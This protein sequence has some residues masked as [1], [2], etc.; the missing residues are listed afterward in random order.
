ME[1]EL[2]LKYIIAQAK[3]VGKCF[4][5]SAEQG[6]DS[7]DFAKQFLTSE[8]GIDVLTDKMMIEYSAHTFMLAGFKR[9]LELKKGNFYDRDVLYL[10]GFLYKYWW[11]TRETDPRII[12]RLAPA[13]LIA[14]RYE[15]YHTQGFEYII[16]DIIAHPYQ[17][18]SK[19][20]V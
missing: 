1:Y 3:V 4:V 12:Y 16:N 15:F 14:N 17:I 2:P 9:A 5:L 20:K 6:Y 11:S 7:D 8:Y 13:R 10:A 18:V 19:A